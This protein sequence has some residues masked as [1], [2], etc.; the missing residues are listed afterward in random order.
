MKVLLLTSDYHISAN[1]AIHSFLNQPE[2]KKGEI[3]VVGILIADQFSLDERS[4]KRTINYFKRLNPLFLI[5]NIVTNVYKQL[6]IG[7]ARFFV[8]KK[9]RAYFGIE[10]MSE[11]N[12]IPYLSVSSINSSVSE[13]FIKSIKPDMLVSCFLLE[14]VKDNILK[15]PEKGSINVHPSLIQKHRGI[16]TSF[17][18]LAKKWKRSGA[19]VHYMNEKIDDGDVIIQKKFFVHPSDS[20]HSIDKKAAVLGGKLLVKALSKI[21]RNNVKPFRFKN[22]GKFFTTPTPAQIK[23][24]YTKGHSLISRKDFFSL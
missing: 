10:E 12:D 14:I 11:E 20:I 21:K 2:V 15:L 9:K 8:S 5:K 7:L 22:V 4:I 3:E 23:S 1:I 17:W 19:T 24:F 6:S 18:A 13:K 16:F